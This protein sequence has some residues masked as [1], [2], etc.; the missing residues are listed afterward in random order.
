[1]KIS[2][3]WLL[4]TIIT[5]LAWGLWGAVIDLT[6]KA[7]FPETL[8]YVVWSLTMVPPALIAL[9]IARWNLER[10]KRSVV[11]G[12][13]A[14]FLGAGGQLILFKTLRVAPAYLVFPL[15]ALSPLVTIVLALSISGERASRKGWA[16]IVLALAAGVLLAYTPP[17]GSGNAGV[18]WVFLALLVFLA[19]G[20]QGFVIS[21]A[22]KIMSAESIFFYMMLTGILLAPVALYMTDFGQPINWGFKGP[23]LAALIQ[24]L[25]AVGALL[26]VYAFRHGKAII[27]SP[28]INAGAPVITIILSLLMYRTIPN[29]IN[30]AGMLAA[31]LATLLMALEEETKPATSPHQLRSAGKGGKCEPYGL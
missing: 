19:W 4:Y 14:G 28:L 24:I 22:N 15:I 9:R 5:M 11:F 26:L 6:A 8:G 7:G 29:A 31:A 12:L 30:G 20:I 17:G 27:V 3:L 1:M 21:R 18:L 16:G 13:A 10:D 23:C 2:R 25:N